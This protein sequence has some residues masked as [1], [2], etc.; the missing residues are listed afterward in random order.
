MD[1]EYCVLLLYK[2]Y[3]VEMNA[4]APFSLSYWLI[5]KPSMG[6]FDDRTPQILYMD[7]THMMVS[8]NVRDV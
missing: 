7:R 3:I 5:I 1:P 4:G 6:D 8:T 2:V